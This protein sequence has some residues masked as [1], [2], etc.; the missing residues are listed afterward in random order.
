MNTNDLTAKLTLVNVN[1]RAMFITL[2]AP[3]LTRSQLLDLAGLKKGQAV[4]GLSDGQ[5][6]SYGN[7]RQPIVVC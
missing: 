2:P 5:A 1:G 6:P 4:Y 3:R 7:Y